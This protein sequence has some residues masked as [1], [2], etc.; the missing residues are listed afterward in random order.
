VIEKSQSVRLFDVLIFGPAMI[1]IG[2]RRGL[3]QAERAFL[4]AG[5]LLTIVY[6]G[7]NWLANER[8][9]GET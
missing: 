5:G 8:A 3:T 9:R 4:L 1:A 2:T 7:A 6:N